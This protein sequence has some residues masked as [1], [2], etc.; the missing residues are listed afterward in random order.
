MIVCSCNVLSD[1]D[2]RQAVEAAD[3]APRSPKQVYGC[4]GCSPECGRCARTIKSIIDQTR[5]PR[6]QAGCQHN[7]Q[8]ALVPEEEDIESRFALA[9]C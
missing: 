2:I 3:E 4:L 8:H 6:A 9:A 5:A 1:Q 7:H